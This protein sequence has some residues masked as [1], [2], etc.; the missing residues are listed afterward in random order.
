MDP[1][2]LNVGMIHAVM[3]QCGLDEPFP[4]FSTSSTQP[5]TRTSLAAAVQK[6]PDGM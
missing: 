2:E 4:D 3:R 6:D 5:G 1:L